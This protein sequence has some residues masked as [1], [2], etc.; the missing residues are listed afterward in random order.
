MDKKILLF[1][2][3]IFILASLGILAYNNL[4]IYQRKKIIYPSDEVSENNYYAL[5]QWLKETG[6]NVRVENSFGPYTFYDISE[7]VI[8]VNSNTY[9]WRSTNEIMEWIEQ[10]GYFIIDI[11]SYNNSFNY[12]LTEFLY[13][14][15]ITVEYSQP[16]YNFE[17][18]LKSDNYDEES[19]QEIIETLLDNE[20]IQDKIDIDRNIYPS[21]NK[22]VYFTITENDSVITIKDAED[23]IRLAEIPIGDGLLTV[24]GTPVFM[25]NYN[26]RREA[27]AVLTW[28]LTG[29]RLTE[30]DGIL[31]VKNPA[32]NTGFSL[33]GSIIERGNFA[34]VII[35]ALILITAGFWMV[36]PL[37]GKVLKEKLQISRPIKDR[38]TAEIR[39]LKKFNALDY[40]LECLPHDDH[41]SKKKY[42]YKELINQ[43]RGRLNGTGKNQRGKLR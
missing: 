35:S 26:L 42:H 9:G 32:G 14:F 10:G 30:N 40:Y 4:E 3:I 29:A 38:L 13:G 37:F 41:N 2:V 6:H 33:F 25:H 36:I 17:D 19:A 31:F 12:N 22:R 39:F 21:F 24:T 16:A 23:I 5:E 20:I 1:A 27:N 15:G 8:M 18:I 43:F 34:P 7:K 28:S 11:A